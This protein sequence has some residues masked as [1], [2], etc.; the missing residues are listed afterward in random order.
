MSPFSYFIGKNKCTKEIEILVA[1]E[2]DI[3]D[4]NS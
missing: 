4:G 2:L 1:V 3:I